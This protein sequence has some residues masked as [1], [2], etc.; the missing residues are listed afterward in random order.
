MKLMQ[1]SSDDLSK[2]VWD[3]MKQYPFLIKVKLTQDCLLYEV[4][5]QQAL[6]D[7][8][9]RRTETMEDLPE[10]VRQLVAAFI[11]DFMVKLIKDPHMKKQ[12]YPVPHGMDSIGQARYAIAAMIRSQIHQNE[13]TH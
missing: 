12:V 7:F 10:P 8:C 11:V 13:S 5:A 6:L 9:E 3:L 1:I 2:C 4:A